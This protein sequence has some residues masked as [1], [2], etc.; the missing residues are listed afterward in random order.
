[1]DK[2]CG[3]QDAT[4]GSLPGNHGKSL[5]INKRNMRKPTGKDGETEGGRL[6][7]HGENAYQHASIIRR[8]AWDRP[9]KPRLLRSPRGM[10]GQPLPRILGAPRLMAPSPHPRC[11]VSFRAHTNLKSQPSA[12]DALND[13]SAI[14]P[15]R[16]CA[17]SAP[18]RTRT[19][20]DLPIR[21]L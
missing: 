3:N 13:S 6:G 12:N 9:R 19:Y 15:Q 5:G 18:D 17:R 1:M 7:I 8:W 21:K 2:P 20:P 4:M 16:S 11:I 10:F 14:G